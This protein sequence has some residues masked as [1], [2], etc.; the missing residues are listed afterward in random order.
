[1]REVLKDDNAFKEQLIKAVPEAR[2]FI[3]S[4]L[5]EVNAEDMASYNKTPDP[6]NLEIVL[7]KDVPEMRLMFG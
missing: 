7:M 1:M 5:T 4:L 2:I 6:I 3:N